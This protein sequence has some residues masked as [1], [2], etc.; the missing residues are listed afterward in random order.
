M[1]GRRA[2]RP[3]RSRRFGSSPIDCVATPAWSRSQLERDAA[4]IPAL[5]SVP[6]AGLGLDI[7]AARYVAAH[8]WRYALVETPAGTPFLSDPSGLHACGDWCLGG[9]VEAAFDSGWAAA[10]AIVGSRTS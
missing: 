9:R 1:P 6:L 8:R 4:A 3:R 2:P 7:H 5:L 10:G